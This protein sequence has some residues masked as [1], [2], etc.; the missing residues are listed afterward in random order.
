MAEQVTY[1]FNR[2]VA[3]M[4]VNLLMPTIQRMVPALS[5]GPDG[6]VIVLMGPDNV[7][8][9]FVMTELYTFVDGHERF[10][11]IA[12]AKMLT[13]Q[14]NG[15]ATGHTLA[16]DPAGLMS[17]DTVYAGGEVHGSLYCAVSGFKAFGDAA[18]ARL[19]LE[20]AQFIC[21][22]I[23]EEILTEDASTYVGDSLEFAREKVISKLSIRS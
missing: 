6:A 21:R 23:V 13:I 8:H 20:M 10:K 12:S 11:E 5:W 3:E 22:A 2:K 17:T 19:V 4:A 16:V 7:P 1:V 9:V 15:V 14:R 18:V